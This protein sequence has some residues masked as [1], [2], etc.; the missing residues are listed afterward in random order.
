MPLALKR[1]GMSVLDSGVARI[2]GKVPFLEG[3]FVEP[4][5]EDGAAAVGPT[6]REAHLRQP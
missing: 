5:E 6:G 4:E 3:E 1:C 2:P